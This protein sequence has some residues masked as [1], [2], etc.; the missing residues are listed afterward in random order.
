MLTNTLICTLLGIAVS[1]GLLEAPGQTVK[2]QRIVLH[3][4]K[5]GWKA[6][7][8]VTTQFAT[9]LSEGTIGADDELRLD[10]TYLISGT[11]HL[12]DGFTLSAVTG[13]GFRVIDIKNASRFLKLDNNC[14]LRNLTITYVDSPPLGSTSGTKAKRGVDYLPKQAISASDKSDI[15]IEN[16]RFVGSISAHVRLSGCNRP[17]VTS[18]HFLGSYLGVYL[19]GD[20]TDAVI[21]NCVFE[22]GQGDGIK[23][24]RG[25]DGTQRAL[26][27]NCVF[28][29]SGRDGIDT[30]GGWKDS[31]V[32]DCIFRRLFSGM[33]IKSYFETP[34]HLTSGARNSGILIENCL[35]SDT[36]NAI[37]F[38]T[39]D[40]G[41]RKVGKHF[42][43]ST[44]CHEHAPNDVDINNCVFERTGEA[45]VRMLLMKGGHSIRY[46]N[47]RF[48]GEGIETI[49]NI[50][51]FEVFSSGKMSKEVAE[52]LNYGVTGTLG[53]PGE[54]AK[55]GDTSIPFDY[56]PHD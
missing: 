24:V 47:A 18:C 48:R 14:T 2:D 19:L 39:L 33:D 22:K 17:Q 37:T 7:Q 52:A 44:N 30:T 34:E 51:V 11:H 43:N 28:Q 13:A 6:N 9:L 3:S 16:C 45:P 31:I 10:H 50:N 46:R 8:D 49:K 56:G 55:S 42:L 36:P 1:L 53:K 40:R 12:P 20:V 27:E 21:R 25:G 41:L 4:S 15:R 29:D 38:S 54:P 26:V 23:T 35:F 5:L 32:R